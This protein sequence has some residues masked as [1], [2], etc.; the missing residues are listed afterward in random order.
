MIFDG[1]YPTK[2]EWKI[3][4]I[5]PNTPSGTG[6]L[7]ADLKY[8]DIWAVNGTATLCYGAYSWDVHRNEG[9]FTTPGAEYEVSVIATTTGSAVAVVPYELTARWGDGTGA[10]GVRDSRFTNSEILVN[11]TS[12]YLNS[13]DVAFTDIDTMLGVDSGIYYGAQSDGVWSGGDYPY[14]YDIGHYFAP[15]QYDLSE[16]NWDR[17]RLSGGHHLMGGDAY[18]AL[19][20][21][22]YRGFRILRLPMG[23]TTWDTVNDIA[24]AHRPTPVPYGQLSRTAGGWRMYYQAASSVYH[25]DWS[26]R[27]TH[28][29]G[30]GTISTMAE[31]ITGWQAHDKSNNVWLA[32]RPDFGTR[33]T[34]GTYVALKE[35]AYG[36]WGNPY[37]ST[38]LDRAIDPSFDMRRSAL[39]P[40]PPDITEDHTPITLHS[41]HPGTTYAV[42]DSEFATGAQRYWRLRQSFSLPAAT[43][44]YGLVEFCR[45][46]FPTGAWQIVTYG[47]AWNA[48]PLLDN[49]HH[50]SLRP[51]FLLEPQEDRIVCLPAYEPEYSPPPFM[52]RASVMSPNSTGT[53]VTYTDRFA[54]WI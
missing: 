52:Y 34:M 12:V 46:A 14:A 32:L 39:L 9:T 1:Q 19:R 13:F 3:R 35:S 17:A 29:I 53:T 42:G 8:Y 23:A 21:W 11:G 37:Y 7:S 28:C 51:I 15:N 36:I 27:F 54:W 30:R 25:E 47:K 20:S 41:V 2:I 45:T 44:L 26:D 31:L 22:M 16:Y 48:N 4:G 10:S 50:L 33:G 5:Q 38:V 6:V 40:H 24:T 49:D 18:I 43:A